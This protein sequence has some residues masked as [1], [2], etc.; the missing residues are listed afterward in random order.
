[1]ATSSRAVCEVGVIYDLHEHSKWRDLSTATLIEYSEGFVK[2]G[3]PR[4]AHPLIVELH[5]RKVC[6]LIDEEPPI[7][8]AS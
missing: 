7:P 1:V 2:V 3:A 6:G 8:D 4:A 5:Y